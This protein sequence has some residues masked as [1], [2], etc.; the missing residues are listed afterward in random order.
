MHAACQLDRHQVC[1]LGGN[2][3]AHL[4]KE[5]AMTTSPGHA[6][7]EPEADPAIVRCRLGIKLKELREQ[8]SLRLVDVA[9]TLQLAP[10]TLSRIENGR[11]PASRHYLPSLLDAYGVTDPQLRKALAAQARDGE[12]RP[13]WTAHNDL[14]PDGAGRYLGLEAAAS[15]VRAY[16]TQTVPALLQTP[17][18]AAAACHAARP[19]LTPSQIRVLVAITKRRQERLRRN[20]TRL[21]QIID[22]SPLSRSIATS[23]RCRAKENAVPAERGR[24]CPVQPKAASLDLVGECCREIRTQ[25]ASHNQARI[26]PC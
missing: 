21:H 8:R 3:C 1:F 14:L 25:L 24:T 12:R 23:C 22:E 17:E 7:I 4:A 15:L 5:T 16:S 18:Y 19:D 6:A 20:G 26:G 10:S 9:A 13:W 2:V 11:A